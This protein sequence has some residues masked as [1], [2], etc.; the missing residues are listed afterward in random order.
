M[1]RQVLVEFAP[2]LRVV[3]VPR[4]GALHHWSLAELLPRPFVPSSLSPG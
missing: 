4:D 2:T 1:C 3:S